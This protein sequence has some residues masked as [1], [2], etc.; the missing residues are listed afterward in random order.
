LFRPLDRFRSLLVLLASLVGACLPS[1]ATPNADIDVDRLP[2]TDRGLP[3]AGPIRREPWFRD[4]WNDRHALW[5]GRVAQDQRAVVFLGDSI[6]QHWGDD[7]GGSFPDLQVANRGIGGDTT[8]GVLVR[9]SHDVLR[10]RPRAVVVLVGTNDVELQVAPATIAANMN[11]ILT[12]LEASDPAMPI[13]LCE[14]FP[15]SAQQRRPRDRILDVNRRYA[16]LTRAHPRVTLLPTWS[17]FA[18]E[19]GDAKPA[20][21]PDLLH[22]N[23][24]GYRRWAAALGPVLAHVGGPRAPTGDAARP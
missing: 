15:S 21:F 9:V 13:V 5:A 17:L 3:G 1:R 8:R 11:E 6:T 20:E 10:L 12:A 19:K 24:T 18:D 4:L 2:E 22:P 16:D 7:L 23:D 14:L